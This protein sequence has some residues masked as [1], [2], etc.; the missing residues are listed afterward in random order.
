MIFMQPSRISIKPTH[1]SI[2]RPILNRITTWNTIIAAPTLQMV[3][4]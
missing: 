3:S 1:N 4:V 2:A